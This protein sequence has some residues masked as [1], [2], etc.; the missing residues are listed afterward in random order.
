LVDD[1]DIPLEELV[2]LGDPGDLTID[3]LAPLVEERRA[4][5]ASAYS[6]LEPL[7]RVPGELPLTLD[8][9]RERSPGL[10]IP[11]NEER[12]WER[13][14]RKLRQA[15]YTQREE[16]RARRGLIPRITEL[17]NVH[18]QGA[19]SS[20]KKH[21]MRLA[22]WHLIAAC[23]RPSTS[24]QTLHGLAKIKGVAFFDIPTGSRGGT[25]LHRATSAAEVPHDPWWLL[26]TSGLLTPWAD[27]G[28]RVN[29]LCN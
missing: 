1:L 21:A 25:Q 26:K 12:T 22:R 6:V 2:R 13:V 8:E 23:G 29:C 24:F 11:S 18:C 27:N 15:E 5:I 4:L 14:F 17:P 10:R 20:I 28:Y 3:Q 19:A 16:A 9:V 7:I